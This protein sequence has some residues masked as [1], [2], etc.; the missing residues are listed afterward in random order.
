MQ[1]CTAHSHVVLRQQSALLGTAEAVSWFRSG[2]LLWLTATCSSQALGFS[3]LDSRLTG[4][5]N[6][7]RGPQCCS[8]AQAACF[9]PLRVLCLH[10]CLAAACP[11]C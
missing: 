2:D 10:S 4:K 8:A 5:F 1:S 6:L 11:A 7:Q 3:C 9:I